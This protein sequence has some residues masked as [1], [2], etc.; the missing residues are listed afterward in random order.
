MISL[1]PQDIVLALKIGAYSSA[2]KK[3]CDLSISALEEAMKLGRAEVSRALHRLAVLKLIR[4]KSVGQRR[5][6]FVVSQN[7]SP[8]ILEGI[9]YMFR[10]EPQGVGRGIATAFNYPGIKS[11]MVP[12]GLPFVWSMVGGDVSGEIIEPL[13]P[14]VPHAA[15]K[16]PALYEMLALVEG[17]RLGNS[18]EVGIARKQLASIIE[19]F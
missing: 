11:E 18:R 15:M 2:H 19:S 9:R 6:Y 7:I 3:S 16:D 5:E 8:L 12:R 10:P 14:G 13:Y 4:I 17:L 1:K